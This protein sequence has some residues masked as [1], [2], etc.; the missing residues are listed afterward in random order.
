MP[1]PNDVHQL[2]DM[3]V[4][5]RFPR[6]VVAGIGCSSLLMSIYTILFQ[7]PSGVLFEQH[8]HL[9]YQILKLSRCRFFLTVSWR[10]S[11]GAHWEDHHSYRLYTPY[12]HG[13]NQW[14][15][16]QDEALIMYFLYC[17][18]LCGVIFFS[19][20]VLYTACVL[21]NVIVICIALLI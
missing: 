21:C 16:L 12:P 13:Y 10:P 5:D 18:Y 2:A 15:F 3:T 6:L 14:F 11:N 1:L 7:A 9:F 20:R 19:R 8:P 4:P 17:N